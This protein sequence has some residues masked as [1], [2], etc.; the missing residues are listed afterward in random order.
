VQ[1]TLLGS[2]TASELW[3]VVVQVLQDYWGDQHIGVASKILSE[4]RGSVHGITP[5][6]VRAINKQHLTVVYTN[7]TK[8]N[9]FLYSVQDLKGLSAWGLAGDRLTARKLL[10]RT[11]SGRPKLYL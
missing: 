11:F 9:L 5:V 6:N 4:L 10:L 1:N 8:R 2:Q 7:S 3:V